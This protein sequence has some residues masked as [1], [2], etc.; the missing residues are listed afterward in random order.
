MKRTIVRG[1]FVLAILLLAFA[2]C[3]KEEQKKGAIKGLEKVSLDLQISKDQAEKAALE[4][5][6]TKGKK[7]KAFGQDTIRN[8]DSLNTIAFLA[9]VN[10]SLAALAIKSNNEEA[11]KD[12][13][14]GIK[15]FAQRLG[16][17]VGSYDWGSDFVALGNGMTSGKFTVEQ[18]GN[19][20]YLIGAK[21]V[22][23]AVSSDAPDFAAHL[24]MGMQISNTAIYMKAGANVDDVAFVNMLSEYLRLYG[25]QFNTETK[26]DLERVVKELKAGM[27]VEENAKY[28]DLLIKIVDRINIM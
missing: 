15:A 4:L 21:I 27:S 7:G 14:E 28:A 19:A 24:M 6:K 17:K 26:E 5:E 13:L 20:F 11:F 2:G 16:T 9:G 18:A 3:K 25:S 23:A 8:T 10:F 1:A 22:Q 12:A